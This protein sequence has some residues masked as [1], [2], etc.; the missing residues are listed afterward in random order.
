MYTFFKSILLN[1][2]IL[3][4]HI[5]CSI[6]SIKQFNNILIWKDTKKKIIYISDVFL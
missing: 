6:V 1:Y 3:T 4:L 5:L 2:E